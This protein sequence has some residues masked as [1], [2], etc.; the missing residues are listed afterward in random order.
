MGNQQDWIERVA[1]WRASGLR[2]VEFC[3][4]R[5]FTPGALRHQAQ[6]QER[7]R[8]AE[9]SAEGQPLVRMARVERATEG[10]AL[11]EP[12]RGMLTVDVG[13]ARVTVPAGFDAATVRAVLGALTQKSGGGVS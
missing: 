8:R 7:R 13:G 12:A 2:A 10:A 4:G 6:G 5:D 9:A 1:A 11:P 3:A